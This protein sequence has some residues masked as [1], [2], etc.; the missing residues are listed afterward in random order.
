MPHLFIPK[1][2]REFKVGMTVFT[3]D[4]GGRR[5]GRIVSM[6][7]DSHTNIH[8]VSYTWATVDFGG[9]KEVWPTNRLH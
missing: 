1:K 2:G 7:Q 9:K 6:S 3:D 5:K 8:G 4:R